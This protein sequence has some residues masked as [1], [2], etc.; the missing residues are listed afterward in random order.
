MSDGVLSDY[1]KDQEVKCSCCKKNIPLE[2][3]ELLPDTDV[4]VKCSSEE[5]VIGITQATCSAKQYTLEIIKA[6]S[7]AS[8]IIPKRYLHEVEP[9]FDKSFTSIRGVGISFNSVNNKYPL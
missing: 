4:C 2:R 5:K 6:D 3:I 8:T 7:H 1:E 9:Q